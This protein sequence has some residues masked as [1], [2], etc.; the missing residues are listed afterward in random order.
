MQNNTASEEN[1]WQFLIKL[2]D[3]FT[4]ICDSE[5]LFLGIYSRR[6]KTYVYPMTGM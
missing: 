2:K 5:I 1:V 6:M 3:T 4:L